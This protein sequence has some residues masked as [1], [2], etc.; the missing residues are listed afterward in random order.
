MDLA[1]LEGDEVVI[2][3]PV[4]A[5]AH[6]A[7]VA[8]DEAYGFEQ[9]TLHVG[10]LEDFTKEFLTYLNQESETGET[11]LHAA[12]DK[13]IFNA[14]EAGAFGICDGADV[15]VDGCPECEAATPCKVCSKPLF[16]AEEREFGFHLGKCEG[17][18][19]ES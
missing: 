8:W 16:R 12:F 4:S 6:A 13:A 15:K 1:N 9:H 5:L 19:V 7:S 2:R 14:T 17:I 18:A 3:I 11:V 10:N